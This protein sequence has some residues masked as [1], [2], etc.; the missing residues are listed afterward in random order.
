MLA[1]IPRKLM[2]MNTLLPTAERSRCNYIA[3]VLCMTVSLVG[4]LIYPIHLGVSFV[5]D[6]DKMDYLITSL[7]RD[8]VLYMY[9]LY[10]SL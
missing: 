3:L 9:I 10:T 7:S 1:R 5:E 8:N 2:V 6:K 4:H